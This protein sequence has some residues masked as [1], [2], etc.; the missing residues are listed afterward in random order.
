MGPPTPGLRRSFYRAPHNR[1]VRS[2]TEPSPVLLSN[3]A[4][5]SDERS[6]AFRHPARRT[7]RFPLLPSPRSMRPGSLVRSEEV[8]VDLV[9]HAR[10]PA[11][12]RRAIERHLR[13]CGVAEPTIEDALLVVTELV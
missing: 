7:R 1:S 3:S 9:R 2:V 13:E 8:S 6:C 11:N 5:S 10:A 12:A 4:G